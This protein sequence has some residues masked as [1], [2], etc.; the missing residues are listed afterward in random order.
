MMWAY[1][2]RRLLWVLA[3][4]LV[5]TLIT[6]LIYFLIPP[7]DPAILFAGKS[8]SPAVIAAI[9]SEF[10]LDRP[11]W[12]Q[13]G[14]FVQHIFLGDKYGWPG[15]GFSFVYRSSIRSLMAG[16]LIVTIQLA[17]G[18]AVVWL[19]LGMSI[20][21]VSAI[22]RRTIVDRLAMGVA[23]FFVS[24]P[25][26]W[27]GLMFLWIFWYKLGIA[28]GTGYAPIGQGFGSWLNHM[29]MPWVVLALLYAA[30][31]ARMTRG[32]MLGTIHEDYIRTARAKGVSERRILFK[33]VLRP[34]ILPLVTMFGMDL[35]GLVGGAIIVEQVFNLQGM[36]QWAIQ[37][38]FTGDLPAIVA[39]T[40]VA[41]F[42]ITLGNVVV[43]VLYA[44]LD[45][46]V[47]YT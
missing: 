40:L 31:Y 47:R 46:R 33:H 23:L 10:G 17:A 42:A 2:V 15:L 30:W 27:L 44:F 5:I 29:I 1:I 8:P 7:V 24:A 25:A 28:S 14:L 34:S 11:V 22:R 13:Y 3:V 4:L 19:V 21:I 16:R 37:S 9:K 18:A 45:P 12:V 36:G 39:V 38:I 20:G 41:S 43:D 26:F 35:G 32:S 6:Y